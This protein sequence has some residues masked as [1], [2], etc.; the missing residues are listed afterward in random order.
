MRFDTII[1]S[2][3]DLTPSD[4]VRDRMFII[5]FEDDELRTKG[6]P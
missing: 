5:R 3:R 2:R 1:F 6:R 4:R